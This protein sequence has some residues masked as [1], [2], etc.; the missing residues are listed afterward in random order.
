MPDVTE[1]LTDAIADS[2]SK[3]SDEESRRLGALMCR[4]A[5]MRARG[6]LVRPQFSAPAQGDLERQY[7]QFHIAPQQLTQSRR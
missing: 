1:R 2:L 7:S 6:L 5:A 4:L 3:R